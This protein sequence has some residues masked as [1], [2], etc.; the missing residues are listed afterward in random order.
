MKNKLTFILS[1][2][3]LAHLFLKCSSG[4][5]FNQNELNSSTKIDQTIRTIDKKTID[6]LPISD[7][8][9]S[10]TTNLY[11]SI[12]NQTIWI[13]NG[14]SSES[15]QEFFNYLNS[16]IAL[17]L[18]ISYLSTSPF[19]PS[20]Q[21]EK[22]EVISALRCAEFLFLKD[23]SL[24]NYD[25]NKLNRS[26]L[27]SPKEFLEFLN[28]KNE[29]DSWIEHLIQYKENNKNLIQLHLALNKFTANY[30]IEN[31]TNENI[32]LQVPKDS[33]AF[34]FTAQQLFKRNF[35]S[36]TLQDTMYLKEKLAS[37]Q[38]L[39]GLNTDAKLGKKTMEAL[40]ETNYSRY[41]KGIIALDKLRTFPDS[42]VGKKLIE[43]NIPSYLLRLY[44]NDE[45]INTS[46]VIIGTQRNQTPL[47]TSKMKHIVVNP[48][49]N[50]PYSIASREILPHLKKDVTYL[51]RKNYS[52]LDRNRNVILADSIDWSKYSSRN[53]PFFVRQEPGPSNSL[54]LVKLIFPNK[55][56]IYIHDTPSKHLFARDERT[57][58]HGCV[59]TQSPFKLVHDILSA[60]NHKYTDSIDVLKTRPTETYLIL[61]DNFPV[62]ISYRTAGINDSTKQI[63]FYKDVYEKETDLNTL[64][65]K[66]SIAL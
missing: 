61:N 6:H 28:D 31:N 36:D 43:I 52:L 62:T 66:P 27:I 20:D 5:E 15:I 35:I 33:L 44:V 11:T 45:I 55:N 7:Y 65:K 22:K 47:F 54:G 39:N 8:S 56:S 24:I 29:T 46:K 19:A 42:L 63:Q 23:S 10:W 16:D 25:E 53:F 9:K 26:Q 41:L 12:D 60:E 32:Y 50:V 17:N 3:F 30:G 21:L 13:K 18:P 64:F 59:R 57:F 51:R 48:Y 40:L 4:A 37:F 38:A 2:L 34:V 14:K 49:W 1:L 58:S